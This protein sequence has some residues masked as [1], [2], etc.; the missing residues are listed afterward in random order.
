MSYQYLS[1]TE[2]PD[3]KRQNIYKWSCCIV[4]SC[5]VSVFVFLSHRYDFVSLF[6][7]YTLFTR[8]KMCIS[9]IQTQVDSWHTSLFTPVY[10]LYVSPR[11]PCRL[12]V[13]RFC[14]CCVTSTNIQHTRIL[15]DQITI[16]F[17]GCLHLFFA[18]PNCLCGHFVFLSGSFLSL[19]GFLLSLWLHFVS[20][21]GCFSL[22]GIILCL[23]FGHHVFL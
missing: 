19:S 7:S 16:R 4:C 10:V 6:A 1:Y 17:N 2:P 15:S 5:L 14:Y 8:L 3:W 9:V 12:L 13:Y 21:F 22:F 18:L 23:F 20:L 11:C